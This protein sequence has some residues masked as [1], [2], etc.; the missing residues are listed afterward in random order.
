M[1]GQGGEMST[2]GRIPHQAG[3]LKHLQNFDSKRD[4]RRVHVDPDLQ[5]PSTDGRPR[6]ERGW[7]PAVAQLVILLSHSVIF[8]LVVRP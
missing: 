6:A 4:E 8:S 7:S 1:H 3:P 2:D 5:R